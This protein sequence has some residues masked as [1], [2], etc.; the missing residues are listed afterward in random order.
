[1][2]VGARPEKWEGTGWGVVSEEE[3]GWIVLFRAPLLGFFYRL[4]TWWAP[5][6]RSAHPS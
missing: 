1:V 3:P 4:Q 6:R 5:L 2:G